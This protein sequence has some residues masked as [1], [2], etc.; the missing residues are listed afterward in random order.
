MGMGITDPFIG[1]IM[2][3]STTGPVG[4]IV[5]ITTTATSIAIVIGEM[6]ESL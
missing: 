4:I 2:Q 6:V 3:A 1:P 5:T